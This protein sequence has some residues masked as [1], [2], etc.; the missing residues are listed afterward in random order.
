MGRYLWN[1]DKMCKWSLLP[2]PGLPGSNQLLARAD[3]LRCQLLTDLK[4]NYWYQES[5]HKTWVLLTNLKWNF[6]SLLSF[7]RISVCSFN[8]FLKW[9]SNNQFEPYLYKQLWEDFI[10][11]IASFRHS[12]IEFSS[13]IIY[14]RYNLLLTLLIYCLQR[15]VR[16]AIVVY[17][18]NDTKYKLGCHSHN[19]NDS[20]AFSPIV[21][22]SA[23]IN[24]L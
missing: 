2:A 10:S 14:F 22:A 4:L 18:L 23:L 11:K 21:S 8:R 17:I 7:V 1:R 3:K 16:L 9:K 19:T 13:R 12:G 5:T 24:F 6:S 15:P 20:A